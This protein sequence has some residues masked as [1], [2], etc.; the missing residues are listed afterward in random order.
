M[1]LRPTRPALINGWKFPAVLTLKTFRRDG[2]TSAIKAKRPKSRRLFILLTAVVWLW[3]EP[4]W[5]FLK[6]I[7]LNKGRLSSPT[8]FGRTWGDGK[9]YPNSKFEIRNS[10]QIRKKKNKILKID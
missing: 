7:R 10:K 3:P 1:T 9:E 2:L 6:I 4:L 5:L 8:S